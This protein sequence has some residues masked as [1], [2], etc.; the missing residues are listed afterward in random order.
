MRF[1]R[2]ISIIL[3]PIVLPTLVTMIYFLMIPISFSSDQKLTIIGLIFISTYLVPILFIFLFRRLGV[4][5]NHDKISLNERKLPV[6]FMLVLFYMIGKTLYAI[7]NLR[8]LGALFFAS[9]GS[10]VTIYVL[11]FFKL[12]TSLHLVAMGITTG[13]F[14]SLNSYYSR[15]FLVLIVVSLLLAGFLGSAL[16]YLRNNSERELYLGFFI[17]MFAPLIFSSYL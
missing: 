14:L 12:R 16:L 17:G 4:I 11:S 15:S 10:L 5:T 1:L 8:D 3:H 2:F 9:S 7:P 6:L 13:F